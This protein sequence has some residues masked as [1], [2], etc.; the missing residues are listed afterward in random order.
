MSEGR[1]HKGRVKRA[2]LDAEVI[3]EGAAACQQSRILDAFDGAAEPWA[4]DS[5]WLVVLHALILK[6]GSMMAASQGLCEAEAMSKNP[7][8]LITSISHMRDLP[9]LALAG[10]ADGQ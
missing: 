2:G 5:E 1:A 4:V 7:S 9:W 6:G 3:D 10:N 8:P